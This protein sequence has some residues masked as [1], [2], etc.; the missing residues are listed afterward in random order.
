MRRSTLGPTIAS[1]RRRALAGRLV[2][3]GGWTLTTGAAAG[4]LG[5]MVAKVVP[6]HVDWWL[7]VAGGLAAGVLAAPLVAL[8]GRWTAHRAAIEIDRSLGLRDR[9]SSALE[10]SSRG[11]QIDEFEALAISQGEEAARQADPSKVVRIQRG[12]EWAA[13]PLLVGVGLAVGWLAPE[14]RVKAGP[15]PRVS[16]ASPAAASALAEV[17]EQV[18]EAAP[19]R[20]DVISA[21]E[22]IERELREGRADEAAARAEAAAR[23][24]AL[25]E[26]LA[27]KHEAEHERRDRVREAAARSGLETPEARALAEALSRDEVESLEDA[28]R[29]LDGLEGARAEEV[30]RDLES[31]AAALEGAEGSTPSP[32]AEDA[33]LDPADSPGESPVLGDDDQDSANAT[34][35]TESNDKPRPGAEPSAEASAEDRAESEPKAGQGDRASGNENAEVARPEGGETPPGAEPAR[36][37]NGRADRVEGPGEQGAGERETT[38][39]E[40]QR[41]GSL[42]EAMREA[43]KNLRDRAIDR[44]PS[45]PSQAREGGE[46]TE[47]R[48]EGATEGEAREGTAPG[49]QG[50]TEQEAGEGA[51][52]RGGG[53]TEGEVGSSKGTE[54]RDSPGDE[55]KTEGEQPPDG[56]STEREA[57]EGAESQPTSG[58]RRRLQ[59]M[60]AERKQAEAGERD[61]HRLREQARRLLGGGEGGAVG[62]NP[63]Q[64]TG[65]PDDV[66]PA[67]R[68]E[69]VDARPGGV[70]P[71]DLRERTVGEWLSAPSGLGEGG[72]MSPAERFLEASRGVDRAVEEQGVPAKRAEL[73]RRVFRRY[74][75]RAGEAPR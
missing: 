43:A 34:E 61:A 22:E 47:Q 54:G 65:R 31:L 66:P 75:E 15:E 44:D 5:V 50:A 6:G 18:R 59:E 55:G 36:E 40:G 13:W 70:M 62:S 23:L 9:V 69:W 20:A 12:R 56:A 60:A 35:D 4:V 39:G 19:E 52:P 73:V 46:P 38:G 58:L 2:R 74:V 45:A 3:A 1:V 27:T 68:T 53:M 8:R 17:I 71:G 57:G 72:T 30:A 26:E 41:P 25:S 49:G 21:I 24:E 11:G 63:M 16:E 29:A 10:F 7:V 67:A 37:E 33:G 14:R 51:E 42:S 48:G 64:P 28:L 32:E